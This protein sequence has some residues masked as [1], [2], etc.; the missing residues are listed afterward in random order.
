MNLTETNRCRRRPASY[1]EEEGR[2][3]VCGLQS[4]A[5]K[6]L[7]SRRDRRAGSSLPL[8]LGLGSSEQSPPG[9]TQHHAAAGAVPA[10]GPDPPSPVLELS[11]PW[12]EPSAPMCRRRV[13]PLPASSASVTPRQQDAAAAGSPSRIALT[14]AFP[15]ASTASSLHRPPPLPPPLPDRTE[16]RTRWQSPPWERAT[17]GRAASAVVGARLSLRYRPHHCRGSALPHTCN[18]QERPQPIKNRRNREESGGCRS[19]GLQS[20]AA[21]PPAP[22]ARGD[23]DLDLTA[24][25]A[26]S[27]DWK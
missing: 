17:T 6:S 13:L 15:C 24:A 14:T 9:H 22:P 4:A 7:R 3:S 23:G 5:K 16:K 19:I 26:S 10:T 18:S 12:P 1:E 27:R 11:P 2:P 20:P 25:A 21:N 8:A